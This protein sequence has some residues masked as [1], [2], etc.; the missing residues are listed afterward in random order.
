MEVRKDSFPRI[1]SDKSLYNANHPKAVR[2]ILSWL[3]TNGYD[4]IDEKENYNADIRC[5]K[6]NQPAQFELEVKRGWKAEDYP[7]PD[8]RIPYRK[9]RLIEKWI[10]EGSKGTLTFVVFNYDCSWAWFTDGNIVKDSKVVRI[11]N[12][13]KDNESFF[14][15]NLEDTKK[16]NMK[17]SKK[18]QN[19]LDKVVF[20]NV[21]YPEQKDKS[22]SDQITDAF[23][24]VKYPA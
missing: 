1:K 23:I 17:D 14:K 16:I 13:Y 12:I 19:E 10:K 24:N 7:F 18:D 11:N 9:N 15:I 20:V 6:D 3:K 21:R 22:R 8:V 2:A 5:M 4:N